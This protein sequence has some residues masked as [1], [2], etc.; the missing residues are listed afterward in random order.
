VCSIQMFSDGFTAS[1]TSFAGRAA[2]FRLTP[3]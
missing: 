2:V 1:Q 3:F